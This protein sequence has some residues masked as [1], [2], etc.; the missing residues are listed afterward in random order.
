LGYRFA[1]LCRVGKINDNFFEVKEGKDNR[2][3]WSRKKPINTQRPMKD[4]AADWTAIQR[5]GVSLAQRKTT[6]ATL[7]GKL[8]GYKIILRSW[9]P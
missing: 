2:V 7:V 1:P 9:K 4:W 5:I 6:Q 8:S 3:Q